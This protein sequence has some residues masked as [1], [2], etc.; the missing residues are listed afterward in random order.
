MSMVRS[1]KSTGGELGVAVGKAPY[2]VGDRTRKKVLIIL[3]RIH[4]VIHLNVPIKITGTLTV[5]I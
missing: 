3:A 4:V 2:K 5:S 1:Q